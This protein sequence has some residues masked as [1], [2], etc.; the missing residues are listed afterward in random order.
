MRGVTDVREGGAGG[1]RLIAAQ[2]EL[3]RGSALSR[4][5][6][7]LPRL[8]LSCGGAMAWDGAMSCPRTDR[9]AEW[10]DGESLLALTL[11]YGRTKAT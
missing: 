8:S 10:C 2:A 5:M 1:S 3:P 6:V 7:D 4:G 9:R 11:S